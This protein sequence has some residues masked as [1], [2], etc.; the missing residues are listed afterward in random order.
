[1]KIKFLGTA[2]AEG[3][4]AVFCNCESCKKAQSL[5]GKNVRTRS[6]ILVNDDLLVDLPPDTYMHKLLC[7]LDLSKVRTLLV[8]HSHMD[9]FY[10]MELS[11]RGFWYG[12]NMVEP[13][14]NVFCN[15]YVKKSFDVESGFEK[16]HPE[17][18]NAIKWRIVTPFEKFASGNYEIYSLKARHTCPE[19]SLFYLIKQGDKA[20]LQCNDTGY[21]Y[22]ENFEFLE[23]TGV[24]PDCVSLDCTVGKKKVGEGG[25]MGGLDC[26]EV[27]DR[28]RKSGLVKPNARFVA[29]HF[30]HN[31]A[32]THE[33]FTDFFRPYGIEAAYDGMEV[34]V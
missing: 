28:M 29:T 13:E 7:G 34:E 27:A 21:L 26:A 1:M 15:D 22:E 31:S 20:F 30:S 17:I 3:W 9:H 4:P 8:T 33:E 32:C 12:M 11:M 10:P 23:K 6:Q 5:G 24:K 14:L 18:A 16:F 25:H 2:A 19:Q